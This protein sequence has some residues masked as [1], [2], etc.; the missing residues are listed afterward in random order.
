MP[1]I[2]SV[3]ESNPTRLDSDTNSISPNVHTESESSLDS[4]LEP[5][6]MI[7]K[8]VEWQTH[9]Y[10]MCSQDAELTDKS[11]MLQKG[12]NGATK[13]TSRKVARLDSKIAQMKSD[14][15]FDVHEA[16]FQWSVAHVALKREDADRRKLGLT[17]AVGKQD[18]PAPQDV[19]KDVDEEDT[20]LGELFSSLPETNNM[21]D[22]SMTVTNAAGL[23][24]TTR[25]FGEW[26][27]MAPRRILEES[28]R[29]R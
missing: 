16:E 27:G 17:L 2:D 25:N 28:C 24:I 7:K 8:Y 5:D 4:D 9:R 26:T 29:A 23:A 14:V 10:R 6:E 11:G 15:L 19:A 13:P 3:L 20:M 18:K 1:V 12:P 22:G 21:G